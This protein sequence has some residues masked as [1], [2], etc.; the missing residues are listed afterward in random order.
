MSKNSLRS[1]YGYLG[2]SL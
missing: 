2:D 1:L